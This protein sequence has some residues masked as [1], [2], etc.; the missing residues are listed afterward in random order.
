VQAVGSI[1]RDTWNHCVA[2]WTGSS[3][4]LYINGSLIQT[5]AGTLGTTISNEPFVIGGNKT[6]GGAEAIPYTG[7]I[8]NV[9]IYNRE[10]S[11]AEV[12]QNFNAS[13]RRYG[14]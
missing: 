9:K 1:T 7:K 11:A 14:L 3:A 6:T 12:T 10:I 13:R 2:V 5:S 8:A 4:K